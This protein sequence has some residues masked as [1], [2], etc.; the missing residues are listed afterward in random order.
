M[1]GEAG[2]LEQDGAFGVFG[3]L[4]VPLAFGT[5]RLGTEGRP[6]QDAAIAVI[7]A[8][9]DGGIRVL[10]TADSYALDDKDMHYGERLVC[11][12]L[13]RWNGPKEQVR[14]LTKVGMIRPKGRWLPNG[15]VEHLRKAV[16]GSLKALH[17]DQLDCLLLH[18]NDG[19]A[20]FEAALE[21]FAELAARGLVRHL[22]LCNVDVP[23]LEQAR[24]LFKVAVVQ[25]ELSVMSRKSAESGTLAWSRQHGASFL[26]HR[27]L[28][29]HAKVE[30][31]LKNRAMKPI[32]E[33]HK[34]TPHQ[35]A[36]A[37]LLDQG[38]PLLPLFGATTLEHVEQSLAALKVRLDDVDR[39]GL[40]D[41]MSFAPDAEA[42]S[43]LRT[44]P[45]SKG[46]TL[47]P[48]VEPGGEPEVVMVMGV[49]GAGKSTLVSRYV[50]AGFHRLNR[51][52]LG[53]TLDA[54]IPLLSQQLKSDNPRVVLDNTYP[55]RVSR[56]P[57]LRAARELGVPVRCHHLATPIDEA[58]IN[59]VL[60]ILDRHGSLLGPDELKELSKSDNNLPP[61][62]ALA[63][64]GACFE[65]PALDEGFAVIE[66]HA[67]VRDQQN[68][69][70]GTGKALLL[71]VDGTLRRTKSGEI[72]PRS[73][74]DIE[75]LPG[76]REVLEAWLA[77][78]YQL[79][80]V[81]NQSGVASGNVGREQVEAGFARTIELLGL[82]V[83]DVAYCPH[84]AF[85]AGCFCRK[86]MP[87]M[88]I[89]LARKHG[90]DIAKW[91]MVGDMDSDQQFAKAIGAQYHHADAFFGNAGQG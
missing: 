41:K 54:L 29:G 25:N 32:A 8:A 36:L 81:S 7:H 45:E 50:E 26:A 10:D 62:M 80:L 79:F 30:N 58:L 3:A 6:E 46:R 53:G 78:G 71:D 83:V 28:G 55:T 90:L 72:Y 40:S 74:D 19:G 38:A 63:R 35:A 64:Y 12:A 39:K 61:P 59:I 47:K 88:G 33:R 75:L 9:L 70:S 91:H 13:R 65:A 60:R 67:F 2:K 76:R 1:S 52:Q 69:L 42:V 5:L 85:P 49:Q 15:R 31:L 14:V 73:A 89:W 68:G 17:V 4:A 18:G 21:F 57:V 82:P 22:G 84:P 37:C 77:R 20:P 56:W 51:D 27:P 86:P 16:E 34:I 24:R 44:L 23:E 48:A 11:E 87:G 66:T 43:W